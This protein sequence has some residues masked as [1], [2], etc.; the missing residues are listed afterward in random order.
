[1]MPD[2]MYRKIKNK[3]GNRLEKF[4]GELEL[5]IME[6]VWE[7]EPIKV[8]DVLTVLNNQKHHL[9]YTSV[10]TVMS[11][12]VEK[13]WLKAEKHGR[14]F[15]YCTVHSRQEAEATAVGDVV[16]ALLND[17]GDVAVA[18]FIKELDGIS[19]ETLNR[20]AELSR[21]NGEDNEE[22]S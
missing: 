8:S 1:M 4:L 22:T 3:P 2:N 16:R 9:A 13:G 17:F 21:E 15:F 20:L 12:L 6:I 14:A 5:A 11:R 18:E 10:M 19:P 7:R